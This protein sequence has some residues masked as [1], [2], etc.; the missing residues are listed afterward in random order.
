MPTDEKEVHPKCRPELFVPDSALVE[1]ERASRCVQCR[2][3]PQRPF[4]AFCS[5]HCKSA[6]KWK[7]FK[8]RRAKEEK[9]EIERLKGSVEDLL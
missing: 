8:Q 3:A 5:P 6:F 1:V 2:A 4:S 7:Q 9:E